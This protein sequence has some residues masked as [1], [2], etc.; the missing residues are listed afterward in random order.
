MADIN[1]NLVPYE[2]LENKFWFVI[3]IASIVMVVIMLNAFSS[4][5][6]AHIRRDIESINVKIS[7]N[8]QS[9]DNIKDEVDALESI[10]EDI[11]AMESKIDAAN[12][13]S[14]SEFARFEGVILL[15]AMSS[16]KPEG[17]WYKDL[18]INSDSKRVTIT[19]H[20]HQANALADFIV[21]LRSTQGS[22]NQNRDLRSRIYFED[23][24]I[25]DITGDNF[26]IPGIDQSLD[27]LGFRIEFNYVERSA[28]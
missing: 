10:K 1:I 23:I 7:E 11:A 24:S 5:Q 12:R 28:L 13:V 4:K 6:T 15:E 20:M 18:E 21:A 22:V 19:G 16:L 3:E 25:G 17:M 14:V 8:K 26:S 27:V 2:E 9:I